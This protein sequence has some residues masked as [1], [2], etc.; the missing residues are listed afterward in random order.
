VSDEVGIDEVEVIPSA[1]GVSK[2]GGTGVVVFRSSI[3]APPELM[4]TVIRAS[5]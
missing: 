3:I 4:A 2:L 1:D 5:T